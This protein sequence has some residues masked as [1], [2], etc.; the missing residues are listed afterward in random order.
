MYIF[1]FNTSL[2][3]GDAGNRH[4]VCAVFVGCFRIRLSNQEQID[5]I[6]FAQRRVHQLNY[7]P[8]LAVSVASGA[9]LAVIQERTSSPGNGWIHTKITLLLILIIL[10]FVNRRQIMDIDL[11]K[12]QALLVHIGIFFR[13]SSNDFSCSGKT[14]LNYVSIPIRRGV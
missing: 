10:G 4:Y 5:G 12:P 1:G 3:C 6:Q 2:N 13:F 7:Y 11:H 8:V 9:Y 14:V